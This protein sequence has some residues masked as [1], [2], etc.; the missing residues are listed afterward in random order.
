[1]S[2]L[3]GKTKREQLSQVAQEIDAEHTRAKSIAGQVFAKLNVRDP[4]AVSTIDIDALRG[5]LHELEERRASMRM[6][7]ESRRELVS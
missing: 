3:A 7:L 1:M 5:L 6:L 4:E 2:G